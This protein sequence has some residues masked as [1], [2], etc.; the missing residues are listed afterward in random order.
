VKFFEE[1]FNNETIRIV[2]RQF[3]KKRLIVRISAISNFFATMEPF[4]KDDK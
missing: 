2:E 4:N 1:K 3:V